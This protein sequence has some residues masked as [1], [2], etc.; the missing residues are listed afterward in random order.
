MKQRKSTHS[1]TREAVNMVITFLFYC[2][3]TAK[4]FPGANNEVRSDWRE[5]VLIIIRKYQLH[6][7]VVKVDF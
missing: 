5:R 7:S 1:H 4:S 6:R 2:L 3:L